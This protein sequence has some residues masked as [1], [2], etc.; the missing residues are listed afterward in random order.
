MAVAWGGARSRRRPV[1]Q[2][3]VQEDK[4]P[5]KNK[6]PE[7]APIELGKEINAMSQG[8]VERHWSKTS[9]L[10]WLMMLLWIF[11]SF[12]VHFFVKDLNAIQFLGFPLGFYMAAQGSLVAFVVMLFIFASAQDSI[13]RS[14][15][16][17]EE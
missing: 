7:I 8:N 17:G 11:F 6:K 9:S 5:S 16:F 13:D 2:V 4:F 12:G 14:E 3:S 10:M 15:G 1:R